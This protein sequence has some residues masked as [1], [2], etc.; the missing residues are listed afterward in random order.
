MKCPKLHKII[1]LKSLIQMIL[2]FILIST[3]SL[4]THTKIKQGL[5]QVAKPLGKLANKM[6]WKG[7]EQGSAELIHSNPSPKPHTHRQHTRTA[8]CV[9]THK[10]RGSHQNS[11]AV[12]STRR[13]SRG[14][15]ISFSPANP[16]H[17]IDKEYQGKNTART[18]RTGEQLGLLHLF[19]QPPEINQDSQACQEE[20]GK[21]INHP[22][23]NPLHQQ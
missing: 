10:A 21:Q 14:P 4:H 3:L 5:S 13:A 23:A 16:S 9:T 11:Q 22:E 17:S 12:L 15:N 7:Y 2:I 19:Q 20:Q 1:F 18:A 8:A 6:R